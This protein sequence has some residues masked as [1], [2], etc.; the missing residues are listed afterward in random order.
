MTMKID[1]K[2]S[3]NSLSKPGMSRYYH[4]E[5]GPDVNFSTNDRNTRLRR[6]FEERFIQVAAVGIASLLPVAAVEGVVR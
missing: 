6:S 2:L 1:T 4:H 3:M 5:P